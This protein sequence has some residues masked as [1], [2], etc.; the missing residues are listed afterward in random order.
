MQ[1]VPIHFAQLGPSGFRWKDIKRLKDWLATLKSEKDQ[2]LE[3]IIRKKTNNR[4]D[5]QNRYYRA[6]LKIIAKDT[7]DDPDNLHEY[8]KRTHLPPRYVRALGKD[9]RLPSSTT[10]LSS[11]EFSEYIAK[12]EKESGIPTPNPKEIYDER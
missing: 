10:K 11:I 12:I 4:T 2:I 7:G 3:V 6:Y 9:I 1:P 5:R 8:F